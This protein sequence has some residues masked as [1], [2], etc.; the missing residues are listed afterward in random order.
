MIN[1]KLFWQN[2][3]YR[4]KGSLLREIYKRELACLVMFVRLCVCLSVC[5]TL[6]F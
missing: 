2:C 3:F 1:E 5:F 6:Y 4:V